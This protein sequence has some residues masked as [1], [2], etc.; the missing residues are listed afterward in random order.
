MDPGRQAD[1]ERIRETVKANKAAGRQ[2]YDG[3]KSWEI[4]EYSRSLMFGDNNEAWPGEAA[5]SRIV[6]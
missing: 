1:L 2:P 5:W 6:D 4:G 3:L